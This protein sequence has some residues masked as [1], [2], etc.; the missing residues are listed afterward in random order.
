M[1]NGAANEAVG[2]EPRRVGPP[3]D[4]DAVWTIRVGTA[5]WALVLVVM[6]PFAGRLADDDR[7]WWLW[8][9]VAGVVLGLAGVAFTT[10]RHRRIQR[11]REAG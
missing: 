6:L 9:A 5:V 10:H 3:L 2:N 8:T 11:V 1:T 4:V 7:T